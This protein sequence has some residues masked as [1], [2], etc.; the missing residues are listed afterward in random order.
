MGHVFAPPSG[1]IIKET[2]KVG[3][4]N[5]LIPVDQHLRSIEEGLEEQ[6]GVSWVKK[7]ETNDTC[8]TLKIIDKYL[9][10]DLLLPLLH[11]PCTKFVWSSL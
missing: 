11:K 8:I 9:Y 3:F 4:A 2:M 10:L 7:C 1:I 6:V 5:Q